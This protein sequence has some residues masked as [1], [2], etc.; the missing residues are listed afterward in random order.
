MQGAGIGPAPVVMMAKEDRGGGVTPGGCEGWKLSSPR[1]K[2][3]GLPLWPS[4]AGPR[5]LHQSGPNCSTY[6]NT[7]EDPASLKKHFWDSEESR[8]QREPCSRTTTPQGKGSSPPHLESRHGHTIPHTL[9]LE[10]KQLREPKKRWRQQLLNHG[11][12]F[13]AQ[14]G[15]ELLQPEEQNCRSVAQGSPPQLAAA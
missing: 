2:Q 5:L 1:E 14:Q 9:P 4:P 12:P 10:A 11:S 3:T 13:I 15:R 8:S 7:A 6:R